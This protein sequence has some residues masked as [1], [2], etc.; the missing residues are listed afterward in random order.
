MILFGE[1][2]S[3][4][5][6]YLVYDGDENKRNQKAQKIVT[7]QNFNLKFISYPEANQLENEI[8]YLE[9]NIQEYIL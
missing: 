2:R 5:Y 3:K 9:N 4:T 7:K 6:N 1:L 8:K